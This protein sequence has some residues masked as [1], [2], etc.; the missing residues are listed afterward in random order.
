MT[1]WFW[2][3]QEGIRKVREPQNLTQNDMGGVA[4]YQLSRTQVCRSTKALVDD[5]DDLTPIAAMKIVDTPDIVGAAARKAR[6]R[7]EY[8]SM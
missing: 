5:R 4:E 6:H 8:L 1:G 3:C 2:W 7:A